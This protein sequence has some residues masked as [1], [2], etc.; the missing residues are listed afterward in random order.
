MYNIIN[1]LR[2]N[3]KN[4]NYKYLKIK[5]IPLSVKNNAA[6]CIQHAWFSC[7]KYKLTKLKLCNNIIIDKKLS[8]YRQLSIPPSTESDKELIQKYHDLHIIKNLRKY[9]I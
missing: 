9:Y 4:K 5:D 6:L 8:I 3:K 1:I 7:E 2:K